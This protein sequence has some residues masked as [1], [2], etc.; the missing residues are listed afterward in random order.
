MDEKFAENCKVKTGIFRNAAGGLNYYCS[1]IP[2]N[3]IANVVICHGFCEFAEK[4]DEVVE[5]FL[6]KGYAVYLPEHRGHGYSQ[7][8]CSDWDKVYIR[9]YDDY[10]Q[11]L[12]CFI[13]RKIV[14]KQRKT[15]LFAHSMGG[16][17]GAIFLEK[18]PTIFDAAVF[19]APMFGIRTGKCPQPI[20]HLI[21]RMACLV[22][23]G[24]AYA[25]GQHGFDGKEDFKNSSCTSEESYQRIF[26]L[27]NECVA[28]QTYGGT[29][30]WLLAGILATKQLLKRKSMKK[31]RIPVLIFQA[32]WDHMVKNRAHLKFLIGTRQTSL[33]RI[34]GSKH[35]IFHAGEA[36]REVYYEQMFSFWDEQL[37]EETAV[38]T[39]PFLEWQEKNH[40]VI[41]R[42]VW[43]RNETKINETRK[44]LDLI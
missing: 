3:P 20:A 33:L 38:M 39:E 26:K 40:R 18:Y 31:I 16:A 32:E 27:R 14:L 7:R 19:S 13:Q 23:Q 41:T 29:Y 6:K 25:A 5:A 15:F 10:V 42:K 36:Q 22:G 4:Y 8:E 30:Q 28:Y 11:D 1:Y 24:T 35:E 12:Y 37:R 44:I 34:E 2:K 43:K 21:A 9:S 17:I